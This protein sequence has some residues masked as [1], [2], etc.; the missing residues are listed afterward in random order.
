[1]NSK[2][3]GKGVSLF[4]IVIVV[5]LFAAVAI[6]TTRSTFLTLRGTKKSDSQIKVKENL[7]Y[8]LSIIE[9]QLRNSDKVDI[10]TN[11]RIDYTDSEGTATFFSCTLIPAP[12][13]IDSGNGRLTTPEITI[14][15]CNFTC[16]SQGGG[17][18]DEITVDLTGKEVNATGAESSTVTSSTKVF[19]RNY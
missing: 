16:V 11:T 1:M 6:L 2:F 10:C 9:R 3:L 14:T 17:V 13:F 18:T 4:E 12:G 19:L 5:G 8:A 15:S 7:E